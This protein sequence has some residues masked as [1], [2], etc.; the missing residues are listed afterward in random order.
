MKL[1]DISFARF[2]FLDCRLS[3]FIR[4]EYIFQQL[5]EKGLSFLRPCKW[6]YSTLL[7]LW[8]GAGSLVVSQQAV[9][10]IRLLFLHP[11][12]SS[13]GCKGWFNHTRRFRLVWVRPFSFCFLSSWMVIP[14]SSLQTF[15]GSNHLNVLSVHP[16]DYR[17]TCKMWIVILAMWLFALYWIVPIGKQIC[18]HFSN[19]GKMPSLDSPFSDSY[20]PISLH[21]FASQLLQKVVYPC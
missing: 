20:L 10:D 16:L 9:R 19:F 5:S 21:C 14:F 17:C 6:L 7:C 2:P 18:W 8:V 4:S 12:F 1:I 13:W 11:L 15:F 3:S